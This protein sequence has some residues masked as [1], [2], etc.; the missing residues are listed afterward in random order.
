MAKMKATTFDE[1]VVL[2]GDFV[3]RRDG[4][5]DHAEWLGFLKTLQQKGIELSAEAQS[6]VGQIL[7][8]TKSFYQATASVKGIE[9]AMSSVATET[10]DFVKTHRGIWNHD[11]WEVFVKKVQQNSLTLSD[12]TAVYLG[13]IL[14][15]VKVFYSVAPVST[16]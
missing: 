7:E 6:N 10:V 8:A 3:A 11:D 9:K 1:I 5:W 16:V 14:E 12:E 15:S 4:K 2:A 13:G